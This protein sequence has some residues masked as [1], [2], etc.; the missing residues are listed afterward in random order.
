[1]QTEISTQQQNQGRL[2]IPLVIVPDNV[3]QLAT[4]ISKE[5]LA[6]KVNTVE[7]FKKAGEYLN[8]LGRTRTF[9]DKHTLD[10]GAPFRAE[11]ER[12]RAEGKRY[13]DI[14]KP[15]E[16][17]LGKEVAAY[18]R[19]QREAAAKAEAERRRLADEAR[20]KQEEARI[21]E[22]NKQRALEEAALRQ[23]AAAQQVETAQTD[24]EFK[25]AAEAF[26][27]GLAKEQEAQAV[28][29]APVPLEVLNAA[30]EVDIPQV[31]KPTGA[32]MKKTVVILSS[33][34]SKIPA[35]YLLV[36]E[37][38]VKRHILDGTITAATPGVTFRI[39]ETFAGTGR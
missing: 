30:K 27:A 16:L 28:I 11:N 20:K 39:D 1:M 6:L 17:A 25:A 3:A 24:E 14:I 4:G 32:R 35:T 36:D 26:D 33:D 19:V 18:D 22:E 13:I 38:K 29:V 5:A 10:L 12:I 15:A 21:A 2:A 37:A 34:V 7:D 31:Y 23:A 9:I 8:Q